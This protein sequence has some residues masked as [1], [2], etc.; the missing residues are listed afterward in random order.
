MSDAP[1]TLKVEGMHCGGC[2]RRVKAALEA[3][4][5]A[6]VED[7]QVGSARGSFDPEQTDAAELAEAVN[8]IGFKAAVAETGA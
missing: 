7:V 6:T 1:F 2:V 3:V 4:E 8:R 5:G